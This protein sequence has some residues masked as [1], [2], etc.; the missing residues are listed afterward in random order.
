MGGTPQVQTN[1]LQRIRREHS[2]SCPY[3]DAMGRSRTDVSQDP[4]NAQKWSAAAPPRPN[5]FDP[6]SAVPLAQDS[7]VREARAPVLQNSPPKDLSAPPRQLKVSTLLLFLS[8]IAGFG[9]TSP[10]RPFAP[11]LFVVSLLVLAALV[12][13]YKFYRGRN[14]ARR[15][16]LAT[17]VLSI[18]NVV[19]LDNTSADTLS[20]R[21]GVI[22]FDLVLG[23]YLLFWLNRS[24][25]LTYFVRT[26]R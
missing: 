11:Q 17:S 16:V 23:I 15:L 18:I 24:E 2:F 13:L 19:F 10:Q 12:V 21:N 6:P 3:A 22:V 7:N 26:P 9:Q 20:F 14:W 5:P 25:A 1:K 8:V 4:K